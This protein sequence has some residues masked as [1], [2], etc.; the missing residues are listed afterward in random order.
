LV[1]TVCLLIAI[2]NEDILLSNFGL[3]G[4]DFL[5]E[6][7]NSVMF[8]VGEWGFGDIFLEVNS[9]LSLLSEMVGFLPVFRL[10]AEVLGDE[11]TL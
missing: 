5:H 6:L 9:S 2:C 11:T 3:S 7:E 8:L 1:C 4:D 10:L